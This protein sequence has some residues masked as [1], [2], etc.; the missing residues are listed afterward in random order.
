MFEILIKEKIEKLEIE[1]I[2]R[3][4]LKNDIILDENELHNVFNIVKNDWYELVY[5]NAKEVFSNNKSKISDNNYDKIEKLF[6]FFK[7]K[8]Q[9]FL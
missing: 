2:N 4:A 9:R 3:F 8:Y 7:K 6:Y 1:D 5:G